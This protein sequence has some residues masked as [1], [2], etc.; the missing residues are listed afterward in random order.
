MWTIDR[1]VSPA[2]EAVGLLGVSPILYRA[3]FEWLVFESRETAGR[4]AVG[5][6][7]GCSGFLS[8]ATLPA[9][10]DLPGK[11]GTC[12]HPHYGCRT[13]GHAEPTAPTLLDRLRKSRG[14]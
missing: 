2:F 10:G 14:R 5:F 6:R 12:A 11:D 4:V 9:S 3:G 8:W 13:E 7:T 1:P